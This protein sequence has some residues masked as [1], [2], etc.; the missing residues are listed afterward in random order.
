[1]TIGE[2]RAALPPRT[3]LGAAAPFM[4]DISALPVVRGADTL[5][6]VLVA[7][8]EPS[9]DG[10]P[11]SMVATRNPSFRTA[12]G[13]GPGTTLAEAKA[14]YG[15]A[16]LSYSTND[17]SRE[18]AAFADYPHP[19]IH[20]RVDA[21]SSATGFAGRYS[22]HGEYNTTREYDPSARISLI[23]VDLRRDPSPA[24]I[25]GAGRRARAATQT[26]GRRPPASSGSTAGRRAPCP[27]STPRC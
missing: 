24:T 4:V 12:E 16:T 8:G 23:T 2:L 1:M 15:A 10:A 27:S 14:A 18:Y 22:T 26:T 19:E 11:I 3:T 21:G 20:F 7:S 9:D 25:R 13:V 17:E 5:Y 6:R